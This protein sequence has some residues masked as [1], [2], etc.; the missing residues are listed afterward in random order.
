ML[1]G[2]SIEVDAVQDSAAALQRLNSD[3]SSARA[4]DICL[5]DALMPEADGFTLAQQLTLLDQQPRTILMLSSADRATFT[6]RLR[7][8]H[9]DVVID[10]PVLRAELITALFAA[11][12]G[13]CDELPELPDVSR[14]TSSLHVLVVEDTPANQKVVS[15][16]LR[17]RGH[18]IQ[19]ANNGR[20]AI[21]RLYE[22]PFDVVLMD[23]QM[24]T[25]DGYQATAAIRQMEQNDRAHV[26]IIAMTAHA[27]RGDAERCLKSG[28]DAYLSKPI[29]AHRLVEVVEAFAANRPDRPDRRSI[30][31]TDATAVGDV[32]DNAEIARR[33]QPCI[34]DFDAAIG[35]LDGS[36][37]LL[38]ELI[39][40]FQEDVPQLL[41]RITTG[42]RANDALQVKLASHSIKGLAATFNAQQV[43]ERTQ[44]I[45]SLA[46]ESQLDKVAPEL[47]Y[48]RDDLA[49]LFAAL[50]EFRR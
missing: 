13:E 31:T 1:T 37:E 17:R 35:R 30:P 25:V 18:R 11:R 24:P 23:V 33:P 44:R 22:Q 50:D 40:L 46:T 3:S 32:K 29:D 34:V 20:E 8:I 38:A 12:F 27:M 36:S 9:V 42:L 43:V 15:A 47:D 48:L 49:Q 21:E 7:E 16:I 5:I 39:A 4:Y 6:D 45:E 26:P 2:L 28:M 14:V 10:K 19:L 41:Q